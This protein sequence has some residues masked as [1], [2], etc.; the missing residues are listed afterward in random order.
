MNLSNIQ[1]KQI[2]STTLLLKG[3]EQ[4]AVIVIVLSYDVLRTNKGD[5]LAPSKGHFLRRPSN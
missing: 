1:R 2:D 3:D 5:E 4:G